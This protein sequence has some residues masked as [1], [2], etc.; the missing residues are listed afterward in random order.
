M[1]NKKIYLGVLGAAL[2]LGFCTYFIFHKMSTWTSEGLSSLELNES[3]ETSLK[4]HLFNL[5]GSKKLVLATLKQYEIFEKK[6]ELRIFNDRLKLPDI[7]VRASMPVE[8]NYY[9]DFDS[10]WLLTA[11]ES[12]LTVIAP[13]LVTLKPSVNISEIEFEV[14][15]GSLFR[16][17]SLV[18][19]Q[20]R[21]ELDKLLNQSAQGY[22]PSVR[23]IAREELK[24]II[25]LWTTGHGKQLEI[26]VKFEDEK[27]LY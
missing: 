11:T 27:T 20:L 22:I 19:D 14:R 3:I 23:E 6:S 17:D 1:F 13:N 12:T 8:Y 4:S 7:I 21:L 10:E 26:V 24:Q 2:I 15:Q 16:R 25:K 18:M 9:V 5:S